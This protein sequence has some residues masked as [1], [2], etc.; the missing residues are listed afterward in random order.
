[1]SERTA[2]VITTLFVLLLA[3][4]A[5]YLHRGGTLSLTIPS[6]CAPQDG[7]AKASGCGP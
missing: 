2:I 6:A 3:A 1:M 4:V 7:G 5:V